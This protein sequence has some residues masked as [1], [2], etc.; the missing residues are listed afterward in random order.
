MFKVN[1]IKLTIVIKFTAHEVKQSPAGIYLLKVNNRNSRK[2]CE[3]CS[4]LTIKTIELTIKLTIK[5]PMAS[6]WRIYC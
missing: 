1:K 3:I 5:T 4:K 6:F 2:R